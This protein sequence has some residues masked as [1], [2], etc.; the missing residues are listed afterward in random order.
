[1]NTGI[2]ED[3]SLWNINQIIYNGQCRNL[4]EVSHKDGG[5]LSSCEGKM[6]GN[7][8]NEILIYFSENEEITSG[9]EENA[10][11]TIDVKEE[12]QAL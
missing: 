12:L 11:L 7:Y 3:D 6:D 8:A 1:M 2:C 4:Y 5:L 10:M 9:S